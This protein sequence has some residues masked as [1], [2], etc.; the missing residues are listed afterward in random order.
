[1]YSYLRVLRLPNTP[2]NLAL[3]LIRKNSTPASELLVT[4]IRIQVSKK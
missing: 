4:E 3:L 2:T 1:M